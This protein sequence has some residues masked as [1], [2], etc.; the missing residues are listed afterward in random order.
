LVIFSRDAEQQAFSGTF[1]E[2]Q[3]EPSKI[4][5]YA[6]HQSMIA[7]VELGAL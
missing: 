1:E 7:D 3:K 5:Q 4:L 6:V 2:A